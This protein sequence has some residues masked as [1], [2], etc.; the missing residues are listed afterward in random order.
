MTPV[1]ITTTRCLRTWPRRYTTYYQETA[2]PYRRAEPATVYR[3]G[4]RGLVV[5]RWSSRAHDEHQ[6]LEDALKARPAAILSSKGHLL[7]NYSR[8]SPEGHPCATP[9]ESPSTRT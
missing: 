5:G 4:T 2:P 9:D 7:P 1:L 3:F 6:A 8:D